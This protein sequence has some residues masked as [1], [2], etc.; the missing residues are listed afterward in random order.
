MLFVLSGPSGVGKN[1]IMDHLIEAMPGLTQLPT[2]TTRRPRA[3]EQEGREHEFLTEELF[4]RRILEK[5][6]IEWQIIHD[7]GV[8][9]VPRRTIQQVVWGGRP[10]VADVDVL[11]AMHL[12]Q[13]FGEYVVL[14]FVKCPDKA[15]LESRLRRRGGLT[16]EELA[17]RLRR[18]DFEL[19]FA[20]AYDYQIVNEE[21]RLEASVEEVSRIVLEACAHPPQP[22]QNVGWDPS[23]IQQ[24]AT[25]LIVQGSDL[26]LNRGLYPQVIVPAHKLPF[27]A[28]Q[29]HIRAVLGVDVTPTRPDAVFRKV[30]IAFEP[31]Q[32][33][34]ITRKAAGIEENLIY[35]LTLQPCPLPDDLPDGWAFTPA[36]T[37]HLEPAVRRL[38]EQLDLQFQAE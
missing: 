5:G 6:L 28:I 33:E 37:L 23:A 34:R 17:A 3:G 25:A 30:D 9:G 15:T 13:E 27:E 12:K 2:A 16:E 21:N 35:I 18:A 14:I 36:D 19:E 4:R 32:L 20:N 11:G 8:Y 26:L 24:A 1:T 7:K 38:L 10:M 31:P 22:T 29:D